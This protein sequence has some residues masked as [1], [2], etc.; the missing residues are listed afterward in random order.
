MS[1]EAL[2]LLKQ[3]EYAKLKALLS[4]TDPADIALILAQTPREVLPLVYRLLPK[5]LAAEV[6]VEM[7]VD[8]Q[9][10]LIEAFSDK[11]LK[12][13]LEELFLD[14]TVDII[15]EMPANVVKRMLLHSQP[16]M[17]RRINEVLHYPDDSAGSIMTIEYVSLKKDQT[18]KEAFA[19]IR[20]VGP[21]K[22]TIYTCY[23]TGP[24]RK[25]EGVVTVKD[26]LLAA[27]GATI[28]EIMQTRVISVGTLEDKENVAAMFAKYDFMALP[29]V[30]TENRLVGMITVDDVIDVLQEEY[31]EDIAKMAAVTPDDK[32]YLK[33]SVFELWKNRV[34]WLLL[35]MVSAT[36]TGSIIKHFE[37]AL[38]A[39]VA[40]TAFI[41][42]LMDSGGNAGSQ[43]SATIIRG[44]ALGELSLRNIFLVWRKEIGAALLCGL[45]LAV[46][47]FAKNMLFDGVGLGVAF[48]VSLT[49]FIAIV[50]AKITGSTMPLLAKRMG[51]DPAVMASPF[52]TTVVD[53][54]SLIVYFNIASA[55]L[56]L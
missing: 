12:E 25:L 28:A 39:Q 26:M 41:P 52:I 40:L 24:D 27:E 5:E 51:I 21:D 38:L 7:D 17:R 8:A 56:G 2:E 53:A 44:L 29:V 20:A 14:D 37:E 35:L 6:F 10:L 45:T 22:E 47:N 34:P 1:L 36:F 43:A 46:A 9:E 49:L 3:K 11:E 31:T 30:D 4:Q 50:I 42:M 48:V 18:V 33:T 55:V 13:T 32:P 23:V 15:E 19:R 16:E 54:L